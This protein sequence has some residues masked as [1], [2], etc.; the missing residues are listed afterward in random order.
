MPLPIRLH[1]AL[2]ELV[3]GLDEFTDRPVDP[4]DYP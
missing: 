4:M 3:A 1:A 2:G